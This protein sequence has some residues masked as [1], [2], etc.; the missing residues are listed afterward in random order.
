[1]RGVGREDG[2]PKGQDLSIDRAWLT[3]AAPTALEIMNGLRSDPMPI[4]LKCGDALTIS[5]ACRRGF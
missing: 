5:M 2:S 3:T 4:V 1:M